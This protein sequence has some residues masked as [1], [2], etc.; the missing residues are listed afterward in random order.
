[1]LVGP[2]TNRQIQFSTLKKYTEYKEAARAK[3]AQGEGGCQPIRLPAGIKT[4]G[5]LFSTVPLALRAGQTNEPGPPALLL[6]QM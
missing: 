3:V 5:G 1:M 2:A 6:L 4:C